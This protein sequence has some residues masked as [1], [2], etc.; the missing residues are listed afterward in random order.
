M[1]KSRVAFIKKVA[2]FAPILLAATSLFAGAKK[3]PFTTTDP[4]TAHQV[5]RLISEADFQDALSTGR[6]VSISKNATSIM[7]RLKT[8]IA[9]DLDASGFISDFESRF[10]EMKTLINKDLPHHSHLIVP[11]T[12]GQNHSVTVL[13][14]HFAANTAAQTVQIRNSAFNESLIAMHLAA[15]PPKAL[16][17]SKLEPDNSSPTPSNLP[18]TAPPCNEELGYGTGLD[19]AKHP[20]IRSS[21]G[22]YQNFSWPLKPFATCIKD[23]GKRGACSAFATIAAIESS[24][25]AQYHVWLNLSE[26]A[27]YNESK[28]LWSSD[29]T[30]T[31]PG[32]PNDQQEGYVSSDLLNHAKKSSYVFPLE[33]TWEFNPSHDMQTIPHHQDPAKLLLGNICTQYSGPCSNTVHQGEYVC[34]P[35][36]R[37]RKC[38]FLSPI[39]TIDRGVKISDYVELWNFSDPIGSL[40]LMIEYLNAKHPLVATLAINPRFFAIK[41]GFIDATEALQ[42]SN[43]PD[44]TV[45]YHALLIVGYI[46]RPTILQKI[47][48]APLNLAKGPIEKAEAGYFIVKNQWGSGW[49]DGGYAYLPGNYLSRNLLAVQAISALS[50]IGIQP[51]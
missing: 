4:G 42:G 49:G 13:G 37:T 27:V 15:P 39:T 16:R 22:L 29:Y 25:A 28:M 47:P 44:I 45:G 38:G 24:V 36:S 48:T 23:Q 46:P 26:Q 1:T 2:G 9:L 31:A 17:T 33:S 50:L 7:E 32:V 43:N 30:P 10:P 18:P 19:L 20:I 14:P 8:T 11:N 35:H 51:Q 6:L 40:D 3:A 34:T 5:P 12:H 41:D 21:S